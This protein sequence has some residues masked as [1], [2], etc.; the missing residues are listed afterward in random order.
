MI[1]T[2]GI[3]KDIKNTD[4]LK[5]ILTTTDSSSCLSTPYKIN[6]VTIYFISR[7]FTSSTVSEYTYDFVE[8]S[9][10]SKYENAKKIACE[11]PSEENLSKLRLLELE[12]ENAKFFSS[13][14]YKQANP[15]KTFGGYADN[16]FGYIN[17]SEFPRRDL[18]DVIEENREY[19]P[20]WLNPD[21][22]P[23]ETKEK[24][25]SENILYQLEENGEVVEG[26]F[27]LEWDPIGV[28]EGDYFICW[29]WN[30]NLAGDSLSAHM[31][32][33][34]GSDSRM[35]ASIP[36][37]FTRKDKYEIL[38][39]RYLPEMFKNILSQNDLSPF[40]L[41]ELNNSVAKGFTF[42]EDFANQIIDLLDANVIHEQLL[43]LLSNIFN[44]KL[45][46][47]DPTLWRRQTKNAI[48]NFK[49]KGTIGGLRTA[50]SDGGMKLLKFTR[51][52]QTNSKYTYQEVFTKNSESENK[53]TLSNSI[54]LPVNSENFELWFRSKGADSWGIIEENYVLIEEDSGVWTCEWVGDNHP[55]RPFSLDIGD[56]I[57]ILYQVNPIPDIEEQNLE[58]YIR[59][60]ELMDKRD[61]RD[62][63]Y[64]PKNWNT[65]VLEEDD[66]LFDIIIPVRH[67]I[68]DSI[69]WGKVRTEF[70]YSE[71][72]Y[73]ME[74][75]NGSTR[76]SYDPCHI[77][78]NF[79][80]TCKDCQSSTFSVDV[81]IEELSNDRIEECKQ[82][83][84]EF[85]PFH[86]LINS[87]N[88]LGAKNE[89]VKSPIEDIRA[90]IRF[91]KEEAVISG[92][93][94]HI[95][96]RSIS[97]E[98]L[99]LVKRNILASMED[100]SGDVSGQGFNSSIYLF[101]PNLSSTENLQDERF[102]GKTSKFNVKNI[103]L[104]YLLGESPFDNSN[105][106]EVLSPSTNSGVYS[107]SSVSKDSLEVLS[108]NINAVSEPLDR[109]QFEFRVSNKIYNQSSVLVSQEDYYIFR[110]E[111]FN[112]EEIKIESGY[113]IKINDTEYFEYEILEILPDNKIVFSGPSNSDEFST[114]RTNISWEIL[115][116]E[117]EI[118]ASG[119]GGYVTI[120]RRG[121]VDIESGSS[122]NDVRELIKINDYL[123]LNENQYK[124]KS[125][126]KNENYKFYIENYSLGDIGGVE[127][128]VYRRVIENCV[129]QFDYRGLS[130]ETLAN[131]ESSLGIQNGKNSNGIITKSNNL[132]ENYLILIGSDYYSIL[133][134]DE[135]KI[136]IDGPSKDWTTLGT[137]VD[138]TIYKFVKQP[139]NI[140]ETIE[141]P[142]PGH[143][144]DQ[145]SRSNNEII[146]NSTEYSSSILASKILNSI[147]SGNEFVDSTS[148]QESINFNIEYKEE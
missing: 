140:P 36:S 68:K 135:N 60:L 136:T 9:L 35:T 128:F 113:K 119:D 144:F 31:M 78:K 5:F 10:I 116:P 118:V 87:I 126:I 48:P 124:I 65:R 4:K 132:K 41:Q 120:K 22:V 138:F 105:I 91:V 148:Q 46:S 103:N 97:Y 109:S 79:I 110:D 27:V 117:L 6:K 47:N 111:N 100:V 145:I 93:A 121:L 33:T 17:E 98:N 134:I 39:E 51:L 82:I 50:L 11:T 43:P 15:I 3:D 83:I 40:I 2:V 74:E 24:V 123:L 38:M 63:E 52:W 104:D 108:K 139:I 21:L 55:S 45:K 147:N 92:E 89:F 32:F 12:V 81:E 75:Y 130:L 129:G 29:N 122:I 19:F 26:K 13:F 115:S 37:H 107:I 102:K 112:F 25:E 77:D 53:F 125:F 28:R 34:I 88:F 44:L 101:A 96:N 86:S 57:K 49:R 16:N 66:P 141:P 95:F 70:P 114:N 8:P 84:E 18:R 143:E 1:K 56:S 71:N 58:K 54:I 14:Y 69:I 23:I 7:E 61:E 106:L 99:N 80:D 42:L 64:P 146:V 137:S 85:I 90:L 131:Y 72:I 142:I 73:N 59:S 127:I 30:P 67:P 76:D 94:Q 133:D 62:Q 20:A